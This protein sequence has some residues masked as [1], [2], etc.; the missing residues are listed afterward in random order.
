MVLEVGLDVPVGVGQGH[1]QLG[2][3]Q[4]PGVRFRAFLGVADRPARRHQPQLAWPDLLEAAQ[5]VAVQDLPVVQPA[6]RL[7]AHVGVRR[8][9]HAGL[10]GDVVGA[11][12]IHECPGA[13]H[14]APQVG[15]QSAHLGGF[16]ELDAA[17]GEEFTYRFGHDEAASSADGDTG[18]AIEIAHGAQPIPVQSWNACPHAEILVECSTTLLR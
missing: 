10:V 14:A 1:P 17:R 12:V 13:D 3:V 2:P 8:H 15:Q 16:A 9:L 7:K 5:A 11:V 4:K 18:L 6:D